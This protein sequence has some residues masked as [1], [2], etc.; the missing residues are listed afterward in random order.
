MTII[1]KPQNINLSMED[2]KNCLIYIYIYI[3][4]YLIHKQT[5]TNGN[6]MILAGKF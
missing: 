2:A 6:H 3:Y 5:H 4:I 1:I